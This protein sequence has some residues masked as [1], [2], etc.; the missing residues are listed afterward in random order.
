VVDLTLD[1]E[2]RGNRVTNLLD[3]D[4]DL[5]SDFDIFTG[6]AKWSLSKSE[7]WPVK[8]HLAA[9][10]NSGAAGPGED[11]NQGYFARVQVGDY[12]EKYQP[13]FRYTRYYSEPDAIFYVFA[14]SDT[15]RA[16]DVDGH[17]FDFRLGFVK[18]SYFNFT[19]YH[20]DPVYAEVPTMDRIQMDY[21]I[22]F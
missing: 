8:V 21:I 4:E 17:R 3:P 14:Q 9:Y 16:S 6:F 5:Y 11:H 18:R 2:L 19:W 1:G 22:R 13:M 15:T 10:H 7:R 20:T 12:G